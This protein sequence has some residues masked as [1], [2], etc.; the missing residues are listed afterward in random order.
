MRSRLVLATVL[1][2]LASAAVP[3]SADETIF[4]GLDLWFTPS[5]GGQVTISAPA[6]HFCGGTSNPITLTINL[7]G[8]PL[9]TNPVNA[10]GAT[11]TVVDRPADAPFAG[12]LQTNT[13]L[14]IRALSLVGVSSLSILCPSGLTEV[15]TTEV[16]LNGA[17]TF[18]TIVIRRP[19]VGAAGGDFDASF[20]VRA[21]VVFVNAAGGSTPP[22]PDNVTVTTLNACWTH[23]APPGAVVWPGAVTIDTNGDQVPDYPSPYGTSN[24]FAGGCGTPV[25]HQGPHPSTCVAPG[26]GCPDPTPKDPCTADV[27]DYLKAHQVEGGFQLE[28]AD[29]LD[30]MFG[31]ASA[32]PVAAV[33]EADIGSVRV[34]RCIA[35]SGAAILQ[36]RL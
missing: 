11:D 27:I 6:G 9:K 30:A 5:G 8:K 26:P 10:L 20:Q 3:A 35:H 12:G 19:A 32:Q 21:K 7:K 29:K 31:K 36:G 2:I 1:L 17:Q 22:L 23:A 24:F 34:A 13:S 15:Y 18:G 16:S 25:D 33:S 4:R 14:K 28:S